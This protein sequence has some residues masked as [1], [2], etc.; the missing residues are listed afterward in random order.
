MG[1]LSRKVKLTVFSAV[2]SLLTLVLFHLPFF[3][4][5]VQNVESG[6]NG[7]IIIVC[8]A[9]LM[10]ALNFFAC[11]LLL[12]LGRIA[13]KIILGLS[14]IGN[15]VTLY[16]INTYDVIVD[17]T[18]M[19]NVWNTRVSEATGFWGLD[20]FLYILLLGVLPFVL[21][22]LV[23]INYGSLK[24]FFAN[25]GLA[26]LI[27]LGVGFG[28]ITNWP[29]IDKNATILGSLLM[30]W[31]Y[32]V[33]TFRYKAQERERNR[34]EILLPDASI[35]EG[36]KEVLVLV[37][38]ES[39]RRENFSLYGY[40]R[41]T[42]PELSAVEGLKAYVADANATYTTAGVKAILDSQTSDKLYE[43]LPNYLY[44]TGVDVTWRTTNW[45]ES[46]LKVKKVEGT[47]LSKESGI[48]VDYDEVLLWHLNDVIQNSSSDKVFIV[49][50][51]STSHGPTYYKKYPPQ[52]GVFT[53][54]STTVEMSKV[55]R[56][57]LINAY[58]N[59]IIY[60]DHIVAKLIGQ[61]KE[62]EDWKSCVMYVSDHGESLG[63]NNLYMHGVPIAFAPKEQI[64]IPF[65]V[66]SSDSSV[67]YKDLEKIDQSYV[68]HSVLH[69]LHIDSP[70]YKQEL[71]IFQ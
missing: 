2:V 4:H 48:D 10:L 59:S 5:A 36:G 52:Y 63:E 54:V 26:L 49:L 7:T 23:K 60:T 18:M 57:E 15:A 64:E 62:L 8:L 11:Y 70:V 50:H 29:W 41:N 38:G 53:P 67:K 46:P 47:E 55:D 40:S 35:A 12:Y 43:I 28:N 71:D 37:I 1:K 58:D 34:E 45:G 42:N 6:F 9:L 21:I 30:P 31:S 56:D 16:F 20:S 22:M 25:I 39:A 61:M 65:I 33:N 32:V 3:R 27:C 69:F 24:R 17:D 44:R 66:W 19:G 13:G 68:F 14:F 51:T